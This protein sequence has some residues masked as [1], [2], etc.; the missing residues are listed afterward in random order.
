MS[1]GH[2]VTN[3]A[4]IQTVEYISLGTRLPNEAQEVR[5]RSLT[6]PMDSHHAASFLFRFLEL[7]H[8]FEVIKI[9]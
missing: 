4:L 1:K 7:V 6:F 9:P 2:S 3:V 8:S 5:K